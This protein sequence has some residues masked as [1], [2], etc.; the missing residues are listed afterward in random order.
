[1]TFGS[2]VYLYCYREAQSPGFEA[3]PKQTFKQGLRQSKEKFC[4]AIQCEVKKKYK[5]LKKMFYRQTFFKIIIS[6]Q[7]FKLNYGK[8]LISYVKKEKKIRKRRKK[9]I[10]M[11]SQRSQKSLRK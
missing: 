7:S 2:T 9:R 10:K 3:G 1:M 8:Y 11:I 5:R 6:S 4:Y